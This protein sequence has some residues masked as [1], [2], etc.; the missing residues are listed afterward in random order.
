[1]LAAKAFRRDGLHC[2]VGVSELL[3]GAVSCALVAVLQER[4]L[5]FGAARVEE[6]DALIATVYLGLVCIFTV[7]GRG[8][9]LWRS[10]VCH[11]CD[12]RPVLHTLDAVLCSSVTAPA[13]RSLLRCLALARAL[14][15][16]VVVTRGGCTR[17]RLS[18]RGFRGVCCTLTVVHD[19]DGLA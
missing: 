8:G 9:L 16:S 1:M 3:L 12:R 2:P 19:I 5:L 13:L 14:N 18:G 6:V 7:G 11:G 10:L 17:I 15:P 4:D